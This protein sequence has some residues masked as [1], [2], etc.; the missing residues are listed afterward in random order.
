MLGFW[1]AVIVSA[2]IFE[3]ATQL[4]LTSIW[5]AFGGV[6]SLVCEVC[7]ADITTQI[8]VVFAVTFAAL[9][10]TRPLVRKFTKNLPETRLNADMNIGRTGKV[11]KIVDESSG[12]FRVSV[13]GAD[14]SAVTTDRKIPQIGSFVR[15]ER[16]EGVKLV[17][18]A[19]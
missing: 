14:W 7:G 15:V 16:I 12:L 3:V 17:V 8:I 9:I 11:T 13:E 5:S 19:V 1:I 10:L 4:Q 2:C 18:S 6:A